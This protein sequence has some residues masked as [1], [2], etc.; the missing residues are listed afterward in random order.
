MLSSKIFPPKV[1]STPQNAFFNKSTYAKY[2][3]INQLNKQ[4]KEPKH[5]SGTTGLSFSLNVEQ[6]YQPSEH[7]ELKN[8]QNDIFNILTANNIS[9]VI[10]QHIID[11]CIKLN[12]IHENEH[13]T[14]TIKYFAQINNIETETIVPPPIEHHDELENII[15]NESHHIHSAHNEVLEMKTQNLLNNIYFTKKYIT[16][17]KKQ[18]VLTSQMCENLEFAKHNLENFL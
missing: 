1:F 17:C 12:Q 13:L 4:K 3:E 9:N 14:K 7:V 6:N 8:K 5:G 11:Y 16:F 2:V 18:E 10:Q 15:H